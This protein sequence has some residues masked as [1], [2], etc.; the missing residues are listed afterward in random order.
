MMKRWKWMVIAAIACLGMLCAVPLGA[1]D[2]PTKPIEVVVPFGPGG[3]TDL[4]ARAITDL[5]VKYLGQTLVVNN[6]PGAAGIIG[7]QYALNSK[8]D[9]YTVLMVGGSHTVSV[10]HFKSLSFSPINDFDPVIRF[11]V[12]R[13][14]FYVKID[15]PWK[16]MKDFI[17]D[18]KKNP[19][20]YTYGSSG[21]GG[22]H[23]AAVI[24][25][26][27][28]TGI[29]LTHVPS[30]A[31]GAESLAALAGG[32]LNMAVASPNEADALVQGGR[33]RC[34]AITAL[35]R[36][37]AEPTAPT[38]RELGYDVYLDLQ[39]G[40]A[41]PKGVPLPIRQKFHDAVK[42]AYD[43]PQFKSKAEK[44][45]LELAYLNGEDFRKAL[46][47]MYDQ[48]GESIKK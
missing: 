11:T 27:K 8:P 48:I 20:K 9:G 25:T 5:G 38:M 21:V 15:S 39:M 29:R 2:Y 4:T 36:S 23:H 28:R 44:L 32:H 6:K 45:K 26:E 13:I 34:L 14:G 30:K 17:E 31:G 37:P 46:I 43:D 19:E 7:S 41:F 1:Q 47:S 22:M 12:Q 16:T 24:V 3:G 42:K 33:V 35:E 18:A 40:F 10:P